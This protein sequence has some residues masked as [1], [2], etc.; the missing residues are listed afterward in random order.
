MRPEKGTLKLG[1][2]VRTNLVVIKIRIFSEKNNNK[3]VVEVEHQDGDCFAFG[4]IY[5]SLKQYLQ[6]ETISRSTTEELGGGLQQVSNVT[7]MDSVLSGA[8]SDLDLSIDILMSEGAEFPAPSNAEWDSMLEEC[9]LLL[10]K[11]DSMTSAMSD[12]STMSDDMMKRPQLA[13]SIES[14]SS[15]AQTYQAEDLSYLCEK[16]CDSLSSSTSVENTLY[17]NTQFVKSTDKQQVQYAMCDLLLHLSKH[18]LN[19]IH[20]CKLVPVLENTIVK[21]CETS[22]SDQSSCVWFCVVCHL[23]QTLMTIVSKCNDIGT[24]LPKVNEQKMNTLLQQLPQDFNAKFN[25]QMVDDRK[26]VSKSNTAL[27]DLREA[28][29]VWQQVH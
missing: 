11:S 5:R 27:L 16:I 10:V 1:I 3:Y 26:L 8:P 6:P 18:P 9:E 20:T 22:S 19:S 21:I 2:F 17:E 4:E 25:K 13:S 28:Y 14:L 15:I 7:S 24:A 29:A 23:A 12:E